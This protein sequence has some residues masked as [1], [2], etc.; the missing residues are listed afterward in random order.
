MPTFQA[1]FS[2]SIRVKGREIVLGMEAPL[3]D[4][5]T[6]DPRQPLGYPRDYL[7]TSLSGLLSGLSRCLG[8]SLG[9]FWLD[10]LDVGCPEDGVTHLDERAELD[11][12]RFLVLETLDHL[13][14]SRA[15]GVD[16]E[17]HATVALTEGRTQHGQSDLGS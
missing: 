16:G 14:G 9:S 11:V 15:V 8:R 10:H 7:R 5:L 2:T 3:R 13:S 17:P 4:L 6:E 1:A 12:G